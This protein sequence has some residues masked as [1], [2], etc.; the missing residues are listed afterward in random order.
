LCHW[1][2]A[3]WSDGTKVGQR[4]L[5]NRYAKPTQVTPLHIILNRRAA[6]Q[7]VLH[8]IGA[9][10]ARNRTLKRLVIAGQPE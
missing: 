10:N 5:V 1:E 9:T 2:L 6:A 4:F 3:A 7:F 8:W